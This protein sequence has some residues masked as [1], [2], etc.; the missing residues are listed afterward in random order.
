MSSTEVAVPGEYEG[1]DGLEDFDPND[2]SIP[3][4]KIDH[5]NGKIED[6]LSGKSYDS[7]DLIILGLIKQRVLWP[8]EMTEE[9]GPPMCKA[10][11]AKVGYPDLKEF[12]W[13]AAGFLD[14]RPDDPDDEE[15]RVT[16]PCE[17]CALKE[18]GSHPKR[19]IP[20]CSEQHTL[21][22]L[23]QINDEGLMAPALLTLQRS[24]IKPSTNYLSSFQRAREGTFIVWTKISL[25][26]RHRG[27]VDFA[28]PKFER[29]P[30]TDPAEHNFYAQKYR[31]IRRF[32][33]TPRRSEEDE[34]GLDEE[35]DSG[36]APTP[37]AA[38]Q[39][40]A[41]TAPQAEAPA[42]VAQQA[43]AEQAAP[44]P[45]PV[46]QAAPAAAAPSGGD[47]DLPF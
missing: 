16:L 19:D 6:S 15:Q 30:E 10:Y 40:T 11:D 5:P 13:K 37:V 38:P 34:E 43:P 3:I 26:L 35:I 8:A 17:R 20:W 14:L 24:S 29:G 41:A 28:I 4:L 18:W 27:T 7:M 23:Q 33:Q 22:V 12:P 44:V 21:A 2:S 1:P 42:P 31:E 46:A 32:V 45:A 9:S 36:P 39:Q 47:D 25:K